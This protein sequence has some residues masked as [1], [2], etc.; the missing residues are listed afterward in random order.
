[1][2]AKGFCIFQ[3]SHSMHRFSFS[4]AAIPAVDVHVTWSM[5]MTSWSASPPRRYRKSLGE[6]FGVS[7]IRE[8]IFGQDYARTLAIWRS[9]FRRDLAEPDSIRIRRPLPTPAERRLSC[10]DA[11][12]LSPSLAC[13]P[14][15]GPLGSPN[16]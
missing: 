4:Y 2:A 5:A 12:F 10:C 3:R 11:E 16:E 6:R 15:C 7:I 9:K 13:M 8:R 14:C 1:M